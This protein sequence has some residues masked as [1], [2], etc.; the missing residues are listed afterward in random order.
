MDGRLWL[1]LILFSLLV[2]VGAYFSASESA[3]SSMN[4]IRIRARAED[5]DKR[6]RS[7]IFIADHFEKALTTLL[8][9][10]NIAHI[11]AAAV[12][13]MFATRLFSEGDPD[14]VT[15]LCTVITTLI[16]F[17]FAEMIPKSFANDRSEEF[18]LVSAPILRFLMKIFTP[19]SA[20]F[21]K[22]SGFVSGFFHK[23]ETPS[24]SEEELFD[25]IDTIEDEGVVDEN[26]S[27]LLK[28]A[29]EFDDTTA[30]DVMTMR[31]DI[32]A[33]DIVL[34]VSDILKKIQGSTHT[35]IPV[36]E[37]SIDHIIGVLQIR[38][39]LKA[40]LKNP[41]MNI[42]DQLYEP[43]FV[44][45]DAKIDDL[46]SIMRQHRFYLAVVR[47]P[48]T[49]QTLGIVTIED[50]LEELVGE[51]WDEDDT[52]DCNFIKLGGNRFQINSRFTVK[53]A[54]SRIGVNL[55]DPAAAKQS[56]ASWIN[57]YYLK[58]RNTKPEEEDS[59]C[60]A[61]VEI[62]VQTVKDGRVTEVVLHRLDDPVAASAENGGVV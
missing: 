17:L 48:G 16:V 4:Q 53:S 25:I 47:D 51:I 7:A 35:R 1:L 62:E 24:I 54:F 37:G 31:Q 40:Y 14:T 22:I 59:F 33:I 8:I 9:G 26:Q 57:Q 44:E 27:D 50:F 52:Y 36:Y 12:A 61:G 38:R 21:M 2:L 18:A 42:R 6:A 34:P 49:N 28:S 11:A 20:F 30:A 45:S 46:L 55:A 58:T 43:F 56:L 39:F 10:N 41:D 3:F 23:S 19:F 29:L 32:D 5:G 13:T 60:Y 15:V